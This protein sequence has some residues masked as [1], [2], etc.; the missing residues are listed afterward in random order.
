MSDQHREET[1]SNRHQEE[2]TSAAA[3]PRAEAD[4]ASIKALVERRPSMR[5]ARDADRVS[6]LPG[7]AALVLDGEGPP[8]LLAD[9]ARVHADAVR[10][11]HLATGTRP[12]GGEVGGVRGGGAGGPHGSGNGGAGGGPRIRRAAL[13]A[14]AAR[15]DEAP[16]WPEATIAE[17]GPSPRDARV[18][19]L[20]DAL[21]RGETSFASPPGAGAR[22]AAIPRPDGDGLSPEASDRRA[23]V[24]AR[25]FLEHAIGARRLAELRAWQAEALAYLEAPPPG[26][27]ESDPRGAVVADRAPPRPAASGSRAAREQ[28]LSAV[29]RNAGD[30]AML[31]AHRREWPASLDAAREGLRVRSELA[32]NVLGAALPPD[33]KLHLQVAHAR[34]VLDGNT[35]ALRAE[36]EAARQASPDA[37]GLAYWSARYHMIAGDFETARKIV[38]DLADMRDR[39]LGEPAARRAAARAVREL[40]PPLGLTIPAARTRPAAR[41][42]GQQRISVAALDAAG[43]T[44]AAAAPAAMH[45]SSFYTYGHVLASAAQLERVRDELDAIMKG[46]MAG[47]ATAA[48]LDQAAK[49][50]A[51][52]A[53]AAAAAAIAAAQGAVDMADAEREALRARAG[54]YKFEDEYD[55][56]RIEKNH[57]VVRRARNSGQRAGAVAA[58]EQRRIEA[59]AEAAVTR[60]ARDRGYVALQNYAS[61]A[62]PAIDAL[63]LW[64]RALSDLRLGQ[65][66][67]ATMNLY[68]CQMTLLTYFIGRYPTIAAGQPVPTTQGGVYS[69]LVELAR[70]L[71]TNNAIVRTHFATRNTQT[72]TETLHDHDWISPTVAS[73]N[74]RV[75]QSGGNFVDAFATTARDKI[76]EKVDAPLLAMALVFVPMAV[77]DSYRLRND[78]TLAESELNTLL[79]RHTELRLLCDFIELPYVKVALGRAMLERGDAE[80]KA[81]IPGAGA[82]GGLKAATT[83][84]SLL[85]VF[86]DP[87]H[88]GYVQQLEE[89]LAGRVENGV[90]KFEGL[91]RASDRLL[92]TIAPD[93]TGKLV[94]QGVSLH[95]L[96]A[97]EADGTPP[98]A[99]AATPPMREELVMLGRRVPLEWVATV[100]PAPVGTDRAAAPHDALLRFSPPTGKETNPAIWA[101]LCEARARLLQIESGFNYLGYRD[102]YAPPWR[103]AYLLERARYFT[104]H[105]RTAQRDYLAFL[106]NAENEEFREKGTAQ[107]ATMELSNVRV[108]AA[109]VTLAE[110]EA[111]AA[112]KAKGLAEL[113][114]RNAAR[115]AS[116]YRQFASQAQWLGDEMLADSGMR[117]LTATASGVMGGASMGAGLASGALAGAVFGTALGPPGIIVGAAAGLLVSGLASFFAAEG[118]ET[119]MR[120][121]LAIAAAQREYERANLTMA[122]REAEGSAGIAR[123][124]L[125]IAKATL[126]IAALQQTAALMRHDFAVQNIAFLRDRTLNAELWYRLAQLVRG[127]GRT[128]LRYA[129]EI[130]YLA[131]Q[132][133]EYE[134]DKRVNVVRF[135][136]DARDEG[137]FVGADLLLRDLDTLEQDLVTTQQ[138]R[139]QRVKYIVSLAREYPTALQQLRETGSTIFSLTLRQLEQRFPGL[140]NLRV[141]SVEV[142]PIALMDP[143][144]FSVEL[145]YAGTSQVRVRGPRLAVAGVA[146]HSWLTGVDEQFPV[147]VR[148]SGAE[149]VVY[150]GL[151]RA[152]EQAAFPFTTTAQR[153]AFEGLGAAAS[154]YVDMSMRENRVDPRS[155]ADVLVTL[156]LSGYHDPALRTAVETAAPGAPPPLTQNLAARQLFPD[157]FY[158]FGQTGALELPVVADLLTL[159]APVGGLRNAA[160][161]FIPAATG[162]NAGALIASYAMDFTVTPSLTL[163]TRGRVPRLTLT[164]AGRKLTIAVDAPGATAVMLNFGDDSA[165]VEGAGA[166]LT[167]ERIYGRP[168]TYTLEVRVVTGERIAAYRYTVTVSERVAVSP[169]VT[170][171]PELTAVGTGTGTL[172]LA[173]ATWMPAGAPAVTCVWRLAG[174][175]RTWRGASA[176]LELAPGRYTLVFTAMRTLKVG[177]YGAQRWVPN[178]RV[179]ADGG[180]VTSNREFNDDGTEKNLANRNQLATHLFGKGPISPL[181]RWTVHLALADN[182]FLR[183]VT[184]DDTERL[185]VEV[186]DDVV[187]SMEYE[188]GSG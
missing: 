175:P 152:E 143:T 165:W 56:R 48:R 91:R 117:V 131:E 73:A 184:E 12:I 44:V 85:G 58:A 89:A 126:Q 1:T 99:P 10:R 127:V 25:S 47:S 141:G 181:D 17:E 34:L 183:G 187:L 136:Y 41:G 158:R 13:R 54:S 83:Y 37:P 93:T 80:Y 69:R 87:Y 164:P 31:E 140:F 176:S 145:T 14:R 18:Q 130:A 178:A 142:L 128:Y 120:N 79:T 124:Q 101:L 82:P 103:F 59:E 168:G 19:A 8:A 114:S 119:S 108:E 45:P 4:D 64:D 70:A 100:S 177:L 160:L 163:E 2:T 151:A 88:L 57:R 52:E 36:L 134:A 55:G 86:R 133:Y 97:R 102:D 72:S 157:A 75:Y 155:L 27:E 24:R 104:E 5:V 162:A 122:Q 150:S 113:T 3:L 38:V 171:V 20:L 109:R 28:L 33:P 154:W 7:V 112:N 95:P 26:A 129:V 96:A 146:G 35:P 94:L 186:L 147:K 84:S 98:A 153:N 144:R 81:A 166:A 29:A 46:A 188:V 15:G 42:V 170:A 132:A 179:D 71:L 40:A 180:R 121:Q 105:A 159:N 90:V 137:E 39:R 11:T 76:S 23:A 107:T 63:L 118:Q 174:T 50:A 148:L 125:R 111:E 77:A 21:T 149:S 60:V 51:A 22:S 32:Q 135:D 66:R 167:A 156:T 6:R 53:A 43:I 106:N 161:L 92:G 138:Q 74:L 116:N 173:A 123:E 65:F 61:V 115:R 78:F 62:R 182:P 30:I 9:A 185:A 67:R 139:Q 49:D 110:T 169:P 68:E 16:R 172:K